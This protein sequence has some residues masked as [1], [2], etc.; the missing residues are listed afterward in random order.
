MDDSDLLASFCNYLMIIFWAIFGSRGTIIIF[1]RDLTQAG[2]RTSLLPCQLEVWS[3]LFTTEEH[4]NIPW[5]DLSDLTS[6]SNTVNKTETIGTDNPTWISVVRGRRS[7]LNPMHSN[8][9]SW[10]PRWYS[11]LLGPGWK[12]TTWFP[13]TRGI[14]RWPRPS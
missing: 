10:S 4:L 11:S 9:S 7:V 2:L 13:A 3:L 1:F 14:Q 12:N 6:R 8:S 5:A